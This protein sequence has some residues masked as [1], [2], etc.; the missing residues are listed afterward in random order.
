VTPRLKI[1]R[2]LFSKPIQKAPDRNREGKI[3][4]AVV[5]HVRLVAPYIRIL[6]FANGGW[7]DKAEAARFR[8]LGVLPGATDLILALPDG[9]C[10][11]WEVKADDGRLSDD[12]KAFI[13]DLERLGH[14]WAIVR[15]VD[16]AR[17]ELEALG[18]Q[19]SKASSW[20]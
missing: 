12:Q 7:R 20:R 5:R 1:P 18:I 8:A 9:R 3:Q 17:R 4:I 14:R 11:W 2:D 6:H 15:S 10:V 13:A 16:D 19:T